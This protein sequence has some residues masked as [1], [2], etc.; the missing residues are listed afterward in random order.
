MN[1][2][3]QSRVI[4]ITDGDVCPLQEFQLEWRWTDDR[5]NKLPESTLAQIFPLKRPKA[6]QIHELCVGF[7]GS[8]ARDS[9]EQCSASDNAPVREWLSKLPVSNDER[10]ALSWSGSLSVATTWRIVC[11][12]WD[13]FCYPS[14]DD[15]F[16]LPLNE[17]WLLVYHHDEKF[18]FGKRSAC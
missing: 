2:I 1:A 17:D 11:E 14:S 10:V 5:W 9:I 7:V 4:R 18:K 3:S 12:Y 6:Y 15:V 16:V 8:L 13:D